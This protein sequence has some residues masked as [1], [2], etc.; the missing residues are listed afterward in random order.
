MLFG[1]TVVVGGAE[2]ILTHLWKLD[3]PK[4][5]ASTKIIFD[6]CVKKVF[7]NKSTYE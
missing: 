2:L 3:H 6:V 7:I 5:I 4:Y 1:T